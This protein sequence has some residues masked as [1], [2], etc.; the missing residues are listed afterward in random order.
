MMI[1]TGAVELMIAAL[2]CA[3]QIKKAQEREIERIIRLLKAD[4]RKT[5]R[6]KKYTVIRKDTTAL[7]FNSEAFIQDFGQEI[8]EKYKNK[9]SVRTE[10]VISESI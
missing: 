3:R 8:Y 6:T 10:F 4:G 2:I 1:R 7:I 5:F 9:T